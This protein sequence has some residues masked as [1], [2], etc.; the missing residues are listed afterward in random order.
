MNINV[1][2]IKEVPNPL[3]K[4]ELFVLCQ[5]HSKECESYNIFVYYVGK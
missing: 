5:L 2:K 1:L 3:K 4:M